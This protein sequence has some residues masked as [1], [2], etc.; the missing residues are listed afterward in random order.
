MRCPIGIVIRNGFTCARINRASRLLNHGYAIFNRAHFD[1]QVTRHTFR[2]NHRELTIFRHYNRLMRCIFAC[3]I[4]PSTA[5]AVILVD[6]CFGD[7]VKI[8]VLP[9]GRVGDRSAHKILDTFMPFFI[10]P[11]RQTC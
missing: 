7:I 4:A 8:K 10:H 9:I 5:D 2:I 3:G 6:H 1:T 11:L